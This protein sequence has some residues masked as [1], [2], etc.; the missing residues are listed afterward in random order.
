MAT[1]VLFLAFGHRRLEVLSA[2]GF[3]SVCHQA[4]AALALHPQSY[5]LYDTCGKVDADSFDRTLASSRGL[6]V[7]ELREKPEWQ[8]MRQMESQI[9]QLLERTGEEAEKKAA[10]E[11]ERQVAAHVD[12]AME[13]LKA[14]LGAPK[15]EALAD[16]TSLLS[17]VASLETEMAELSIDSSADLG[18][19]QHGLLTA[20]EEM[21]GL[22]SF[23]ADQ[24]TTL[25][26]NLSEISKAMESMEEMRMKMTKMTCSVDELSEK[27]AAMEIDLNE[28]AITAS[29]LNGHL[30]SGV[31]TAKQ[32]LETLR[33]CMVDQ[34]NFVTKETE[35][36]EGKVRFQTLSS[37]SPIQGTWSDGFKSHELG[38]QPVLG[39]TL[40]HSA[41][42]P[43]LKRER[44]S[45]SLPQLPP[46]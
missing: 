10:K 26:E 7:L 9:Q 41:S 45:K 14:E 46:L 20:Q 2:A 43:L 4:E 19:V 13:K 25:E 28:Q 5:D 24:L 8:K 29:A 36:S 35:R 23:T 6:C 3:D 32:E 12:A 33:H 17:R 31:A 34:L 44:L 40:W 39:K 37:M 38:I 15:L 18:H 30:E 42:A 27:V 21:Q 11:V 22:R 1:P 16:G